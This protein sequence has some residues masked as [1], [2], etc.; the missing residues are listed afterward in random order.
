MSQPGRYLKSFPDDVPLKY[1]GRIKKGHNL[2]RKSLFVEVVFEGKAKKL[3]APVEL[4]PFLVK[5]RAYG[6]ADKQK[7]SVVKQF[8][9]RQIKQLDISFIR[10][11]QSIEPLRSKSSEVIYFKLVAANGDYFISAYELARALFFLDHH[12]VDAAFRPNGLFELA[13][14][15]VGNKEVEIRFPEGTAY[16]ASNLNHHQ[17]KQHLINLFLNEGYRKSFGSIFAKRVK[18]ENSNNFHFNFVPPNLDGLHLEVLCRRHKEGGYLVHEVQGIQNRSFFYDG[19]VHFMHP[20]KKDVVK[21]EGDGESVSEGRVISRP[22]QPD[23]IDLDKSPGFGKKKKK[24]EDK[25]FYYQVLSPVKTIV[26]SQKVE[27]EAGKNTPLAE[28]VSQMEPGITSAGKKVVEGNANFVEPHLSGGDSISATHEGGNTIDRFCLFIETIDRVVDA[29]RCEEYK[30][31][32]LSLPAPGDEYENDRWKN[33]ITGKAR[34][35][36]AAQFHF[37]SVVFVA[38]DVD[39]A[40]LSNKRTISSRLV[41]FKNDG[42]STENGKLNVILKALSN[43]KNISWPKAEVFDKLCELSI[44]M[45]HPAKKLYEHI[46]NP[47]ARKE[48][49]ISYWAE[50]WQEKIKGVFKECED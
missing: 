35:V 5:G 27:K 8:K 14:C 44:R 33:S 2:N 19:V 31:F 45:I 32:H 36:C 7:T 34:L 11:V 3:W 17:T 47:Q 40:D 21:K 48:F 6:K 26:N 43:S 1:L 49:Y 9:G 46:E 29:L 25:G 24:V 38:L 41:V 22:D 13:S 30:I 4:L 23:E 12:L 10:N 39:I 18:A 28:E 20:R 37:K 16:P 50:K 15:N 42:E